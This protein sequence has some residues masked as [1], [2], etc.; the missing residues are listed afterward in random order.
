M[1]R[2]AHDAQPAKPLTYRPRAPIIHA[3]TTDEAVAY[4]GTKQAVSDALGCARTTVAMWGQYPP[5]R[6]QRQLERR[7]QGALK[8]EREAWEDY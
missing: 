1:L 7:T 6:R 4:Y 8:A 3:M 2:Q 5:H